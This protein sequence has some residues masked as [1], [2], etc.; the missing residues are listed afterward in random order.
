MT[1]QVVFKVDQKLK[2]QAMKKAEQEGITL[3][4]VLKL[5]TQAFVDGDLAVGLSG[6]PER[7]NE[8]ARRRVQKALNEAREGKDL[9]PAFKSGEEMLAYLRS[10]KW[11]Y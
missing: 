2:T 11:K 1:S 6:K 5:A 4:T 9:S 8:R 7:L 3:S 10:G